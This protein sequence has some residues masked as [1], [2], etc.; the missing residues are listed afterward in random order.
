MTLRTAPHDPPPTFL[1]RLLDDRP[2]PVQVPTHP[3]PDPTQA[4]EASPGTGP[5]PAAAQMLDRL[6]PAFGQE[7]AALR[8]LAPRFAARYPRV[9]RHLA[10]VP[11]PPVERL[12]EAFALLAARIHRQ[13]DLGAP[14]ALET[15]GGLLFPFEQQPLPAATILQLEPA[16]AQSWPVLVPR[17][18]AALAPARDGIRCRF[19]TTQPVRLWPLT[20]AAADLD[21]GRGTQA[22]AVLTLELRA[23]PGA[24]L[25]GI[26]LDRLRLFL[27][28][29]PQVAH[30][31][32]ELLVFRVREVWLEPCSG[33]PAVPLPGVLPQPVGCEPQEALF[34]D[35]PGGCPGLRLATEYFALPDKFLFLDLP[36]LGGGALAGLDRA[37]RLR[38]RLDRL[39]A[40]E[41]HRRL[42]RELAPDMF[43]LGCVPAVNLFTHP[44]APIR[45]S[46]RQPSYPVRP[47][48]LADLPE[49][50][51]TV[52]SVDSVVLHARD[53][54]LEASRAL[55]ALFTGRPDPEGPRWHAD[56]EAGRLELALVEPALNPLRPER[57]TLSLD[58]TCS[59]GS[60]PGRLPFGGGSADPESLALPGH[61]GVAAARPLR[62]PTPFVPV[63][64]R[65][66]PGR[67]LALRLALGSAAGWSRERLQ[68]LL[69]CCPGA[70]APAAAR[71]IQG[72]CRLQASPCG[73]SLPGPAGPAP[74]RGTDLSLVLDERCFAGW[75]PIL[76]ASVLE[77]LFG[78]LCS[79]NSFV[80]LRLST[81]QQEGELA[82]WP[83]RNGDTI[84]I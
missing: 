20:I 13:L 2:D 41:A 4:P 68:R 45:L 7:R 77:R 50:A 69:E 74:V 10:P 83:A 3:L 52:H 1:H 71:Q 19:R 39:D 49:G 32:H 27:D 51:C 14:L 29:E 11:D 18:A 76:F 31:L 62:K 33:G 61:P 36:G 38:F 6:L 35:P 57:E 47:L 53:A 24:C 5:S 42:A 25:S 56:R 55:P 28:G 63:P 22:G 23:A 34:P 48:G 46:H 84:L 82:L 12:V 67:H 66:E 75:G 81:L 80:R 8:D 64:E 43:K 9:A 44:G 79:P 73:L 16:P 70:D 37:V 54:G 26:G 72:I 60:W 65:P 15:L 21:A 78:H 59:N 40:R 17:G 30:L 58:L